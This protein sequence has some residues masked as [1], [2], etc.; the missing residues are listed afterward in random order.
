M[1]RFYSRHCQ[2]VRI[3]SKI[4]ICIN[5]FFCILSTVR[6]YRRK[7]SRKPILSKMQ[8][9]FVESSIRCPEN[10]EKGNWEF[11]REYWGERYNYLIYK[12]IMDI[13][14]SLF[15]I[16]FVYPWLFPILFV[17]IRLDSRGP[18]FFRQQR[19]GFLGKTFWCYK[20]R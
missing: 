17:L 6:S 10:W 4:H 5:S 15:V 8:S 9:T 13:V 19:V 14:S 11:V 1:Q 7:R 2:F 12:R 16:I 20:F 3:P 18:V